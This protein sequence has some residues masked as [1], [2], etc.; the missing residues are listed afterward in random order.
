MSVIF[1]EILIRIYMEVHHSSYEETP[2]LMEEEFMEVN[3]GLI[4]L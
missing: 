2:K 1:P 3:K 4:D